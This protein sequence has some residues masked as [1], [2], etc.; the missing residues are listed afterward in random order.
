VAKAYYL[1]ICRSLTYAQRSAKALERAGITAVVM[2]TPKDITTE[3]CGY[4][5]K[6]SEKRL[7]QALTV[8]KSAGM[9]VNR[10]YVQ[11]LNGS[12]SEVFL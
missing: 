1:I 4:C 11:N 6:V 9:G 3:G 2:K 5:V 10:V 12:S 8:L 7:T